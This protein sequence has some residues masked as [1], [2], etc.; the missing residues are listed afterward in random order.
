[1]AR[2]FC[3][4]ELRICARM[5]GGRGLRGIT[6]TG[7][8]VPAEYPLCKP[9]C[10]MILHNGLPMPVQITDHR[11][12]YEFP[13][14]AF[15]IHLVTHVKHDTGPHHSHLPF[16]LLLFSPPPQPLSYA[17]TSSIGNARIASQL[18]PFD[19]VLPYHIPHLQELRWCLLLQR[20]YRGRFLCL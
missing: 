4:V 17:N 14:S 9:A 3:I 2:Y 5:G 16:N 20:L 6:R 8:Q 12:P 18:Y 1:M 15:P 13:S 11:E 7:R 19:M 10:V